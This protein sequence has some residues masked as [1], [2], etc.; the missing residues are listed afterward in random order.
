MRV[1]A[2]SSDDSDICSFYRGHG[3]MAELERAYPEVRVTG[4]WNE[5]ISLSLNRMRFA[6]V[7]FFQRPTSPAHADMIQLAKEARV[8][9]WIDFDDA[10]FAVR[11][12]NPMK[13]YF[14][15]K[16]RVEAIK[17]CLALADVVTV[18]TEALVTHFQPYVKS[19]IRVIPNAFDM[20]L[21]PNRTRSVGKNRKVMA[22]RGS[23]THTADCDQVVGSLASHVEKHPDWS[24]AFFGDPPA[25][26]LEGIPKNRLGR[27]GWQALITTYMD[28][29]LKISPDLL[30]VPLIDDEFNRCKSNS[31]LLEAAWAGAAVIA[32]VFEEWSQAPGVYTYTCR[33]EF[34]ERLEEAMSDPIEL[35][36]RAV[37]TWQWVSDQRDLRTVNELRVDLLEEL[38]RL[39][40]QPLE[41]RIG[42][43]EGVLGI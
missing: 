4:V 18:T 33:D 39:S 22:W 34:H 37:S 1:F 10:V 42:N 38:T 35:A 16:L 9:I 28:T 20:G 12:D 11:D 7:L 31:A 40:V 5:T 19:S 21:F 26:I 23:E 30:I 3:P 13:G 6:D 24:F 8:P 2:M 27:V 43:A 25:S 14:T 29:L 41:A 32:P 36:A 15:D 17:R